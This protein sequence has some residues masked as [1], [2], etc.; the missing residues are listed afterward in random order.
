MTQAA[1]Q[2]PVLVICG[3]TGSGKTALALSLAEKIPLEIISTDSRQ[4]Y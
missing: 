3:A 2:I 1:E 4:V